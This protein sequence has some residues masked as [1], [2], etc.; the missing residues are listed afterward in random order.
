ML[1]GNIFE[2]AVTRV[3]TEGEAGQVG[4]PEVTWEVKAG[5]LPEPQRQME[6]PP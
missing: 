5:P 2:E 1:G 3:G 6:E 4:A